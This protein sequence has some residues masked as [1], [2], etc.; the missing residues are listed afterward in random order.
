MT[1][2]NPLLLMVRKLLAS[3]SDT[4]LTFIMEFTEAVAILTERG[5]TYYGRRML[6]GCDFDAPDGSQ[7]FLT[8][9]EVILRAE[10]YA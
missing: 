9:E 7:L 1:T 10:K 6:S 3:S 5:Y 2:P 8:T 4:L